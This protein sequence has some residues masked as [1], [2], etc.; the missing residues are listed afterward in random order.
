[1]KR[2]LE[3]RQGVER[4]YLVPHDGRDQQECDKPFY[5][6][7]A[8]EQ[9]GTTV[10]CEVEFTAHAE[11]DVLVVDGSGETDATGHA[12]LLEAVAKERCVLIVRPTDPEPMSTTRVEVPP[13]HGGELRQVTVE[14]RAITADDVVAAVEAGTPLL[15]LLHPPNADIRPFERPAQLTPQSSILDALQATIDDPVTDPEARAHARAMLERER[16]R[17]AAISEPPNP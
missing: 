3:G 6:S 12:S 9:P 14:V 2:S 16:R 10:P 5:V 7:W 11:L 15:D 4:Y 17:N 8:A 13:L 1:M